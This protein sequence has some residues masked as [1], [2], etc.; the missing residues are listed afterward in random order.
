MNHIRIF[1]VFSLLCMPVNVLLRELVWD[2]FWVIALTSLWFAI[3]LRR[4]FGDS[5]P[6]TANFKEAVRGSVMAVAWP[7]MPKNTPASR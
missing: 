3:G 6:L 4:V 7:F 1:L 5:P 2:S